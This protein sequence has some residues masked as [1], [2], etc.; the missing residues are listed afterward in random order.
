MPGCRHIVTGRSATHPA[1]PEADLG[2]GF[3]SLSGLTRGICIDGA[4]A[5]PSASQQGLSIREELF[6]A[7]SVTEVVT[8]LG[9]SAG[10]RFGFSVFG[11]NFGFDSLHCT[12]S[13]Q[14]TAYAIVRI[15]IEAPPRKLPDYRL[16]ADAQTLLR[17]S[18]PMRFYERCGDGFVAAATQGGTFI[19][20]IAVDGASQDDLR[21]ITGTAGLSIG[22]FGANATASREVREFYKRYQAR[23]F[24]LQQGGDLGGATTVTDVFNIDKFLQHSTQ[25]KRAVQAGRTTTTKVIVKPYQVAS[26]A[27]KRASF[28]DLLE[29]RETLAKIAI[30]FEE[31]QDA[32]KLARDAIDACPEP[33][34]RKTLEK[35]RAEHI[36]ASQTTRRRADECL[37]QPDRKCTI[38]GLPSAERQDIEKARVRCS[39]APAQSR[40]AQPP[41][42]QPVAVTVERRDCKLWQLTRIALKIAPTKPSGEAWD[43]DGSPPEVTGTLRLDDKR[44]STI[45]RNERYSM[46]HEL[47]NVYAQTGQALSVHLRDVDVMFDDTIATLEIAVPA[48]LPNGALTLAHGNTRAAITARCIE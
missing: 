14:S 45:P 2:V 21:R 26:N 34:H 48:T 7:A 18:G 5:S 22:G 28:P 46:S 20:I 39:R 37:N 15:E 24:I 9:L 29:Q 27:P 31:L 6:Y 8:Q 41:A 23:Y 44:V 11:A 35:L 25:F 12:T 33:K 42:A 19:G 10:I 13:K 4:A 47:D 3:D 36:S 32:E 16:T 40:P 1:P 43:A 30:R 17:K 38:R